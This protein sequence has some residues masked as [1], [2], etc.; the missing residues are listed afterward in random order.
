MRASDAEQEK[1]KI[2]QLLDLVQVETK[3]QINLGCRPDLYQKL[4]KELAAIEAAN[5]IINKI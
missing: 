4:S 2:R 3:R 1:T 5:V